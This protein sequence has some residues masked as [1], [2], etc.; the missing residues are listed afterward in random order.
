MAKLT[1]SENQS[2]SLDNSRKADIVTVASAKGGVGKTTIAVSL[3]CGLAG[4]GFRV[5]L[6]DLDPNI[7]SSVWL[8][9]TEEAQT[10]AQEYNVGNLL[11][12]TKLDITKFVQTLEPG[13]FYSAARGGSL[14]FLPGGSNTSKVENQLVA[15]S[16]SENRLQRILEKVRNRYDIVILD[17]PGKI[18]G[19][20][21]INAF[22]ASTH[23][24][25]PV[26]AE[27]LPM[28]SSVITDARM[29]DIKENVNA[30][31]K[32]LGLVLNMFNPR[33]S[34]T[35]RTLEQLNEQFKADSV[36]VT[37]I[38]NRSDYANIPGDGASYIAIKNKEL[39][40]VMDE[41]VDEFL[42]RLGREPRNN[43]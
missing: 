28:A 33:L 7:S 17:S 10:K 2:V 41:L 35:K 1:V 12:N 29:E 42:V 20:L 4:R 3:A 6:V 9:L 15:E 5:L 18:D 8:L 19:K 37:R 36:F 27:F 26:V 34:K 43:E 21:T 38:P 14:D 25:V 40:R 39:R 31:I 13:N 32:F 30:D 16:G 11:L 24:L 23:Y 22:A